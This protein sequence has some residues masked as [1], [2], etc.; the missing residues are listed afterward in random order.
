MKRKAPQ[1]L[2]RETLERVNSSHNFLN[3]LSTTTTYPQKF[4]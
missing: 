1:S 3:I 2:D 4:W